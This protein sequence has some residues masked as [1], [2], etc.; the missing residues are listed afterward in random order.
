MVLNILT[1]HGFGQ[2]AQVFMEKRVKELTRKL[3]GSVTLHAIDAPQKLPYDETLR[4]WWTYPSDLWD[5]SADT[6]QALAEEM[7]SRQDFEAV[8]FVESF[9]LVL[10]EWSKGCYD[11]VLGFSQG[12]ILAVA[13]CAEL[14]RRGPTSDAPVPRFAL[15]IS[16]FGRPIPRGVEAYPPQTPLPLPSMHIWGKADN[17][18]PG[19]ASESL[20]ALFEKPKV[21]THSGHHFVPQKAPDIEV[22]QEFLAP[23]LSQDGAVNDFTSSSSSLKHVRTI[24]LSD[25]LG[26]RIRYYGLTPG[27]TPALSLAA[28]MPGADAIS[29]FSAPVAGA[30]ATPRQAAVGPAQ[31]QATSFN[32][33]Q[34][35]QACQGGATKTYVEEELQPPGPGTYERLSTLLRHQGVTF[36]ELGPHEACRTSEDSVRVRLAGGWQDVTLNSG[37]KAMLMRDGGKGEK[38]LLI[39]L[40]ADKKL[41]WKKVRALRGK[42]TR[43]ATEE[44]VARVTG[45][46]PGAVP[47]IAAAFPEITECI[48]DS[49]LPSVINF[50]CG[51]RTRSMQMSRE[52]YER[53]QC[54]LVLEI[55]D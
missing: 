9:D 38:W 43:M 5:G 16:G 31:Q 46:V 39:V 11:G 55:T 20:T 27:I 53:V 32:E 17:H 8:G 25:E 50:N 33:Q 3:R 6:I 49:G 1:L 40:P 2:N 29:S 15:L 51:L 18:I 7:L 28:A 37:A 48:I 36:T 14:H 45:C 19:W 22:I 52:A 44:E 13:L 4:G 30:L 24:Y 21:Y 41:S 42:G 23:F 35:P 26:V 12:A 10:A 47:P 34:S 54:P